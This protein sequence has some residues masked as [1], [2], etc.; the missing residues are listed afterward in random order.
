MCGCSAIW[1]SQA[2]SMRQVYIWAFSA[3]AS[4]AFIYI[5]GL[6][7]VQRWYPERRGLVAGFFNMAFGLSAAIMSPLF[8]NLLSKWGY[9]TLTLAAGCTAL[10]MGLAASLL[11]RF[12]ETSPLTPT[13]DSPVAPTSRTVREALKSSLC[14]G[15]GGRILFYIPDIFRVLP[16]TS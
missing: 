5:P 4:S 11:I 14:Q 13:T 6:T 15:G 9:Q 10:F 8:S 1:L 3:G 7:V 16:I 2:D 12:P